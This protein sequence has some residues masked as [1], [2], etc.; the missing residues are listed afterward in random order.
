MKMMDKL[1]PRFVL[2]VVAAL[3]VAVALAGCA[4]T[5]Q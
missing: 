5:L 1:I 4:T 2:M 3:A